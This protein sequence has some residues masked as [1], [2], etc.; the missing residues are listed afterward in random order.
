MFSSNRFFTD[1]QAAE[2]DEA[3]RKA[4]GWTA[5]LTTIRECYKPTENLTLKNFQFRSLLQEA[6]ET[7][8]AFSHRVEKE[9]KHCGFKCTHADCTAE[10]TAIRDQIVI[11]MVDNRIREEALMKSWDL[12]TLRKEGMQMESA[13]KGGAAMS[14]ADVNR[15]GKYSHKNINKNVDNKQQTSKTCYNC[16]VTVTTDIKKHVR[17]ECAAIGHT[18]TCGKVGHLPSCCRSSKGGRQSAKP[19]QQVQPAVEEHTA[20]EEEANTYNVNIFRV[21]SSKNQV[22]PR[23]KAARQITDFRAPVV[24]NNSL[25]SPISDTGAKVSVC[26]TV[27]AKR[28]NLLDRMV[29]SKIKLKPYK[30]APIP[31]AGT[32]T[33]AVTFGNT[34]I[35]VQWHIISGSCEPILAGNDALALGII[36]FTKTLDVFEPVLM[37]DREAVAEVREQVQ[38]ILQQFPQN[39]QGLGRLKNHNVK[40]YTKQDNKPIQDAPRTVPYHLRE[41]TLAAIEEMLQDG[42]IEEHPPN[43]PAPWK[44]NAVLVPKDDGSLRVTMDA[45]NVNKAIQ[46]SNH[47]I[48]KQEDIKAKLAHKKIFSKLDFKSAFWQIEL[49]PESRHLTVFQILDKLF[50]YKVLTMGL[51]P[52]QGELNAALA[53]LFAHIEDVHLIHDDLVIATDTI[54]QHLIALQAVMEAIA[55]AGLTLSPSKCTFCQSE[56]HFWGMIFGEFGVRPDP[57]KVDDLQFITPPTNKPELISFLCMMQSNAEFMPQFAKKS[58]ILRE[59]TKGDVSFHWND[60]HQQ[61][62]DSLIS[63]FKKD[64]TLQ[65]FDMSKPTFIFAD[66]HKFGL[67]VILAQGDDICSAKAVAVASRR[68]TLAE[69]H[70]P[71]I[72]LEATAVDYGLTRY[73]H[74][75]VGA[76]DPTVVVTDHKPLVSIFNGRRKGSIRTERIKLRNQ[77]IDFNVQYQEGKKNQADYL[78]RHAKPFQNTTPQEQADAQEVNKV[79]YMLHTT[80]IMDSIGLAKIAQE[81]ENDETLH[82]LKQILKQPKV[83]IPKD[84]NNSLKKFSKILPELTVS[85]NGIVLKS[86][87][88]VLPS[89]LQSTAIELAHRGSHPA[90]SSMERRLRSHFFFHE[91]GEKVNKFLASCLLCNT[92]SDKKTTEPVGRHEVPSKCWN[93]VAVDLFGPMPSK[94]HVV[95]VQ[96]LASKFPAAKLVTSTGADK[97]LPALSDIYNNYG[98]PE[99]QISDNG[100]P[101]NSKKMEEFADKRNIS[102]NKIP[103]LHPSSNPAETF[104]RPLGKTMKIAHATSTNEKEA[105]STLLNNYRNTPHPATGIA[106]SAM[107]FR[108]GEQSI[109]PRHS[110]TDQDVAAARERDLLLKKTHQTTVNSGKYRIPSHFSVGDQVLVRN[111]QKVRK[112]DPTFLPEQFVVIDVTNN[113]QCI[114]IEGMS[115]G[116]TLKRHPDDLKLFEGPIISPHLEEKQS[117]RDVLHEHM[118]RLSQAVG[119]DD[120]YEME[121]PKL[122]YDMGNRRSQRFGRANPRYYNEDYVNCINYTS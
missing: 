50:R 14:A 109:F 26:G 39:F 101:F 22:L 21:K 78:S 30:S 43:E 24:V 47:P 9:A 48:P 93:T 41:R 85:G 32:A 53:P 68:T 82:R 54:Q 77:D 80:P 58:A 45:K 42:V 12:P 35:P 73:R 88:I 75:L 89:S 7:L 79:L 31:I 62:F 38:A 44:S 84:A 103:P 20:V 55:K 33:C 113:G 122:L 117:E 112:F 61:C 108:D 25:A 49:A 118:S 76:P 69:Q 5:F 51:K 34:S 114:L 106:P 46:S 1:W 17:K 29:P 67:G 60:S 111:Y 95:V 86:E 87:R 4:A 23:M 52:A 37:I 13:A 74:Y 2:P 71:Q 8:S 104:M 66:A 65:Y 27:E 6:D 97:V 90:Q 110:V 56:I 15:V 119:D 120:A 40:L 11:G 107:F 92:F 70:Y 81:T 18:C 59:L 64:V 3:T 28:W 10:N 121:T 94:N 100:P 36:K 57:N 91:M 16:G 63:D 115:N 98:N 99:K 19:V 72:D 116:T 83:W 105:L 102:L 96:D